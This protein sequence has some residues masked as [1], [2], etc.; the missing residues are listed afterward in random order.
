MIRSKMRSAIRVA[1]L[2]PF[3]IPAVLWAEDFTFRRI[4]VA[5]PQSGPRITVQIDPEE[6]ARRLAPRPLAPIFTP[7]EA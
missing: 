4:S 7:G 6:Q 3:V 1:A 2:L 5:P